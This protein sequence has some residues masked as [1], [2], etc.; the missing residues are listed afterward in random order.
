MDMPLFNKEFIY[1]YI[2]IYIYISTCKFLLLQTLMQTFFCVC[3]YVSMYEYMHF[4]KISSQIFN[5]L[6]MGDMHLK[7]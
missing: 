7:F 3:M 6:V 4:S 5:Y 1:I 2:Y